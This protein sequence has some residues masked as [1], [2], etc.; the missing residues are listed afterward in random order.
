M[1]RFGV[2]AI[3]ICLMIIMGAGFFNIANAQCQSSVTV[4][5]VFNN[6]GWYTACDNMV[7]GMFIG[8]VIEGG[9][10]WGKLWCLFQADMEYFEHSVDPNDFPVG[11]DTVSWSNPDPVRSKNNHK[12]WIDVDLGGAKFHS[13]ANDN[14]TP[15]YTVRYYASHPH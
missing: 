4:T 11:V 8:K 12:I 2:P 1:Q 14:P 15:S 6:S 5:G 10:G 7:N 3:I 13:W 9:N